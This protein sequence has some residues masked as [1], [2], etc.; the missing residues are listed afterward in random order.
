MVRFSGFLKVVICRC[1]D[2]LFCQNPRDLAGAFSGS[3][4]GKD[5][6]DDLCGLCVRFQMRRVCFGRLVAVG[7]LAAQP[8][9]A[10][11]LQF[12]DGANL[13]ARIFCMEFVCPVADGV[14]IIAAFH[15]GIYAVIDRNEPHI[16][17][18]EVNFHVVTDLQVLTAW[19]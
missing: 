13:P 8:F 5:L 7:R 17:L 4:E 14:K 3:T 12:L 9:A 18:R 6:P 19:P 16:L 15:C 1:Q 10:F 11:R 2:I